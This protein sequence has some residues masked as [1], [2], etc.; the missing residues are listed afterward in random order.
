MASSQG[1]R[2]CAVQKNLSLVTQTIVPAQ[3]PHSPFALPVGQ[4]QGHPERA[5]QR[6]KVKVERR[7]S[8][9]PPGRPGRRDNGRP[10][11][12]L[13]N[14]HRKKKRRHRF[15]LEELGFAIRH[16]WSERFLRLAERVCLRGAPG[17]QKILHKKVKK[18]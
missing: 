9:S 4:S 7:G 18:K 10:P 15:C 2:H 1:Q 13:Q 11:P 6:S 8:G 5:G 3:C 16:F 12:C 17:T 14:K